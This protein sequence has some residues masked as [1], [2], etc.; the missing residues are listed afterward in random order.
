VAGVDFTVEK[1]PVY[2]MVNGVP[3]EIPEK[4]AVVR[5]DRDIPLGIVG[6]SYVPFQNDDLTRFLDVFLENC[7]ATL[8]AAGHI[9]DGSCV[10]AM[11]K[12]ESWEPL[13]GDPHDQLFMI[14]NTFN[15]GSSLEIGYIVKR[16]VCNNMMQAAFR[17]STGRFS[18]NHTRNLMITVRAIESL[19]AD[20]ANHARELD[21]CLK[22]LAGKKLTA[23][24]LDDMTKRLI[25]PKGKLYPALPAP[26][27]GPLA[28]DVIAFQPAGAGSDTDNDKAKSK[29]PKAL[30]TIAELIESG[31]GANIPGVRGTAYGWLQAVTEYV[32]HHRPV[33]AG[34]RPKE[35][36]YF[37]SVFFGAGARLKTDALKLAIAA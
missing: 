13:P 24:A 35:E 37:E 6:P 21:Q 25:D 5:T 4:F 28:P 7:G 23:K 12:A 32:D 26:D 16:I 9:N 22:T 15:G 10:W 31:M 8:Q 14:R 1:R 27:A 29:D 17:G 20:H 2:H 3:Y 11:A 34:D 19:I 18:I 30:S 33:R 36:A